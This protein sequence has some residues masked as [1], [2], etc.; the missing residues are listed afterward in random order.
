MKGKVFILLL[1]SAL[2]L[3]YYGSAQG[4]RKKSNSKKR[5]KLQKKR[6]KKVSKAKKKEE[7]LAETSVFSQFSTRHFHNMKT[8]ELNAGLTQHGY[9][10]NTGYSRY[11]TSNSYVK[12]NGFW[13][14]GEVK[15]IDIRNFGLDVIYNHTVLKISN[16]LFFNIGGG[17][18][19]GYDQILSKEIL[20][21][22]DEL[23]FG[24]LLNAEG[25]I[26]FS[27]NIALIIQAN[28]RFLAKT[29][30]GRQRWFTGIGVKYS[31]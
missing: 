28:Q 25:E 15:E 13:E 5:L 26:F 31:F 1:I 16:T 22:D 18:T 4:Y 8:V 11:I 7:D 30:F 14:N 12:V 21:L 27:N 3:P 17:V 10:M 20:N 29:D 19:F 9:Y 2:V 24:G 23:N 6:Q